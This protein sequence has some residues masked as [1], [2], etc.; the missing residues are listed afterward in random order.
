MFYIRSNRNS[1]IEMKTEVNN[2]FQ[3]ATNIG[4]GNNSILSSS[5]V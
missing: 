5:S 2:I 4:V 1:E 3:R